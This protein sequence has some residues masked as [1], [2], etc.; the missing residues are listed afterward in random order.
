MKYPSTFSLIS[1]GVIFTLFGLAF[2]AISQVYQCGVFLKPN[3]DSSSLALRQL[4]FSDRFGNLYTPAALKVPDLS[5]GGC[6]KNFKAVDAR[7]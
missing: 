6:P 7:M 4:T 5:G 3:P 1:S 2:P